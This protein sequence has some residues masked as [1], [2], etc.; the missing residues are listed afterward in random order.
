MRI[1]IHCQAVGKGNNINNTE[2]E[3]YFNISDEPNWLTRHT[4]NFLYTNILERELIKFGGDTV[5]N[6]GW[7]STD[8]YFNLVY[9]LLKESKEIDGIVLLAF[10]AVYTD[11]GEVD[12][13]PTDLWVS[14]K[15][16]NDRV[17]ALNK[18]FESENIQ[19]KR[20]F[21]GASVNPNSS[22]W[23]EELDFILEETDAVLI[24]WIPSVQRIKVEK[25]AA[26][27]Y[28]K[29]AQNEMPILCHVGPEHTFPEGM[30]QKEYDHFR[31][32]EKPLD[33]NVKVI[34]AHCNT[35]SVPLLEKNEISDF[36]AFMEEKNR[37]HVRLYADTSALC[38]IT[39]SQY[40]PDIVKNFNHGWLV[41]GSD[42]PIPV[43]GWVNLPFLSH[44]I[45]PSEYLEIINC[46]NPFDQDVIIKRAYG[47]S[48]SILDNMERVLRMPQS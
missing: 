8:E 31:H 14:N 26:E 41:H 1:D 7:I 10:D 33:E 40:L 23:E 36:Y 28:K 25:V 34:A 4:Y 19:K 5:D 3:V 45:T 20:F 38:S 21:L 15:F 11:Q 6:D 22:K 46:K 2:S 29:L 9:R 39:K 30:R 48:D 35:P 43:T 17:I 27:F 13:I 37:D 12:K 47:L 16:L 42:F 24:K 18:R 44:D 32:L